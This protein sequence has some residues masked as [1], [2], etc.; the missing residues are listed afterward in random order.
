MI[1][2]GEKVPVKRQAELLEL[3]RSSVYYQPRPISERDLGWSDLCRQPLLWL[4]SSDPT[5]SV[6]E[7]ITE[8]PDRETLGRLLTA[9]QSIFGNKPT[10]IRDA[11]TMSAAPFDDSVELREVLHDIADERGEVNRRRL[12]WWLK[13]RV[14]RIV[15]GR[16]LC[17]GTAN[18]SAETWLVESVSPVSSVSSG[19]RG[20]VVPPRSESAEAYARASNGK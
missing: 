11:V 3:S 20:K 15:D 17:R 9:W 12:G 18:G 6:F 19:P 1:D 5:E 14:G 16:R 2:R 8:D 10:M 7:A 4:G 13:K